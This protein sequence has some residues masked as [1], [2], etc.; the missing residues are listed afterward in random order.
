MFESITLPDLPTR[1]LHSP[2]DLLLAVLLV[3]AAVSDWRTYRI[4]NWLT[5]GGALAGLALNAFVT[6]VGVLR[7]LGGLGLGLV[8]L[9]PLWAVRVLGAG[10]V[11][12]IAMVGA[13]AGT[14]DVLVALV[15][16]LIAG[17]IAAAGFAL[18][19]RK[20]LQMLRNVHETVVASVV[21]I[22]AGHAPSLGAMPSIGKLPYA[23]G[24]CMGSIAWIV[25]R[26]LN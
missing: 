26:H 16:S 6:D 8:L 2:A 1:L 22:A 21:T 3:T 20:G 12:L 25:Y 19:R 9:L 5:M 10:D 18:S 7:A 11:K 4:P 14:P 24:I 15:F 23:I 13:F 17:G